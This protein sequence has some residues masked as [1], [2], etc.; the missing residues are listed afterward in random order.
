MGSSTKCPKCGTWYDS[1]SIHH[2]DDVGR[3][4]ET[5]EE[6]IAKDDTGDR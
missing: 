6:F 2:C 1:S 3:L 5:Q 4:R